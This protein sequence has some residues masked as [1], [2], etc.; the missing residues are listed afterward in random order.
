MTG[1]SNVIE[2]T[3]ILN[4]TKDEA[5]KKEFEEKMIDVDIY[6]M[7]LVRNGIEVK[8]LNG[9]VTVTI[10]T[11]S[12]RQFIFMKASQPA[13]E[14]LHLQADGTWTPV[15][16]EYVDD[17][18]VFK[19]HE[20]G[21]YALNYGKKIITADKTHL[22]TLIEQ[23]SELKPELYT[24]LSW[25]E[26]ETVLIS[27]KELYDNEE[28]IQ[29][30]IDEMVQT[31]TKEMSNL[32]LTSEKDVNYDALQALV[33]TSKTLKKDE[34]TEESWT[35]FESILKNAITMLENQ[36]ADSQH[37]I[38]AIMIELHDAI[39]ALEKTK[40]IDSI[41]PID[42]VDPN[43]PTQ[44]KDSADSKLPGTGVESP[45]STIILGISAVIIGTLFVIRNKR[46][47][48]SN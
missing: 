20:L 40:S 10:P 17:A 24:K 19:T 47:R 28:A 15:N 21:T 13:T 37:V 29:L 31:L 25:K 33:E 41:K 9:E 39:R 27:A 4:V 6:N 45:M 46:K 22:K 5:L 35:K 43:N 11:R 30:S 18:L 2:D 8:P 42:P 48:Q 16:A 7:S 1:L 36:D 12:T 38:D 44:T 23:G 3:D 32:E 14:L 34:Y 26:F